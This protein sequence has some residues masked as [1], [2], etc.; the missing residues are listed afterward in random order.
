M[1]NE[2]PRSQAIS[3]ASLYTYIGIDPETMHAGQDEFGNKQR[4]EWRAR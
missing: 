3:L 1:A 2:V 4:I